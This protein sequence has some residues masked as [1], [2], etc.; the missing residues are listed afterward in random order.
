METIIKTIC[1]E[2]GLQGLL[3]AGV[4]FFLFWLAK[5]HKKEREIWRVQAEKQYQSMIDVIS[6]NAE[7]VADLRSVILNK[8]L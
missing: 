3:M 5:E 4:V 7:V 6:K 2:Y 8:L 1:V